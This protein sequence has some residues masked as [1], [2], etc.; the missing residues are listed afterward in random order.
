V[1]GSA[2]LVVVSNDPEEIIDIA[3][4]HPAID[5]CIE[6]EVIPES[7]LMAVIY[8]DERRRAVLAVN[9]DWKEHHD[10]GHGFGLVTLCAHEA[11]HYAR[12]VG[13]YMGMGIEEDCEEFYTHL[14]GF[15]AG[16]IFDYLTK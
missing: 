2:L 10:N 7:F 6:Y 13:R 4:N 5:L 3:A 8:S 16:A 12:H 14:S 1:F 9:P 11:D 15:Y